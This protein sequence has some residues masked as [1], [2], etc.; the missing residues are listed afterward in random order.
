M[1]FKLIAIVASSGASYEVDVN[2]TITGYQLKQK[3]AEDCSIEMDHQVIFTQRGIKLR[4]LSIALCD[5]AYNNDIFI[6][7][8]HDHYNKRKDKD[9]DDDDDDNNSARYTISTPPHIYIYDKHHGEHPAISHQY[10][11]KP[12]DYHIDEEK[13]QSS[14]PPHLTSEDKL[15]DHPLLKQGHSSILIQTLPRYEVEFDYHYNLVSYVRH[16]CIKKMNASKECIKQIQFQYKSLKVLLTHFSTLKEKLHKQQT[17]FIAK[18]EQQIGTHQEYLNDFETDL[19]NLQ[20]VELHVSLQT[21]SRKTML[22]VV[23]EASFRVW[24]SKACA[25]QERQKSLREQRLE[26]Q[27]HIEERLSI[28]QQSIEDIKRKKINFGA[29]KQELKN[30][31]KLFEELRHIAHEL[32]SNCKRVKQMMSTIMEHDHANNTLSQSISASAAELEKCREQQLETHLVRIRAI[33]A[34]FDSMLEHIASVQ[35]A[36]IN[37]FTSNVSDIT[38]LHLVISNESKTMDAYQTALDRKDQL[39]FEFVKLKALPDAYIA[40]LDEIARRRC[41]GLLLQTEINAHLHAIFETFRAQECGKR[42]HFIQEYGM[43][44]VDLVAGLTSM[45]GAVTVAYQYR[46]EES[47]PMVDEKLEIHRH[48]LSKE[49]RHVMSEYVKTHAECRWEWNDLYNNDDDDD[50]KGDVGDGDDGA[51]KHCQKTLLKQQ[52]Q[53]NID[54]LKEQNRWHTERLRLQSEYEEKLSAHQEKCYALEEQNKDLQCQLEQ[55]KSIEFP[56]PPSLS[57]QDSTGFD[58]MNSEYIANQLSTILGASISNV[59]PSALQQSRVFLSRIYTQQNQ[60]TQSQ[61]N[62]NLLATNEVL[63]NDVDRLKSELLSKENIIKK[64]SIE[65]EKLQKQ[66]EEYA[67][68][69]E[70]LKQSSSALRKE[71]EDML[72]E[73]QQQLER[74]EMEHKR[75]ME[76]VAD[77]DKLLIL[78][79]QEDTTTYRSETDKLKI[80]RTALLEEIKTLSEIKDEW[81]EK[82]KQL[83]HEYNAYRQ[84]TEQKD[85]DDWLAMTSVLTDQHYKREHELDEY[86]KNCLWFNGEE[87]YLKSE[88]VTGQYM[89]FVRDAELSSYVAI[90]KR[91]KLIDNDQGTEKHARVIL[92]EDPVRE[93]LKQLNYPRLITGEIFQILTH[94]WPKDMR[95]LKKGEQVFLVTAGYIKGVNFTFT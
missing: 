19:T 56:D 30:N 35:E 60:M 28:V 25:S 14:P 69:L 34:S 64:R 37:E 3:I 63:Q 92:S 49:L 29:I 6:C 95:S 52:S 45:P 46:N 66:N 13:L 44:P 23:D 77:H 39:F 82:Y 53:H 76:Q 85:N 65:N 22:D 32:E 74:V 87:K 83:Y 27:Q 42:R 89:L 20:S 1:S 80:G 38:K 33:N 67:Q 72:R 9:N 81:E 8:N 75:E 36:M 17:K 93:T 21:Q 79:L 47:L 15:K 86:R 50:N 40:C 48:A 68:K 73:H 41:F 18:C 84:E 31:E 43:L 10:L 57:A 62:S 59:N 11:L 2:P 78:Q 88:P 90:L 61:S 12:S 91:G 54:L 71:M 24:Y 55:L 58:G 5:A 7:S 51:D 70:K 4:K 26:Q 16:A 94:S